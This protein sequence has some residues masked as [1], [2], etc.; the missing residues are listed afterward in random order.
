MRFDGGGRVDA[1][2]AHLHLDGL[3][4]VQTAFPTAR[5]ELV[6]DVD[7]PRRWSVTG[8]FAGGD[9]VVPVRDVD[10][11]PTAGREPIRRF[12]WKRAQQH[13]PGLEFLVSTG[14][15]HGYES[16]AEARLLLMLDFA[17]ELTD[18]LSQPLRLRFTTQDGLR[19]HIPD[20]F[21]ETR[22]GRW[23]IDV[24]PA[25]RVQPRDEVAFAATAEV[26]LLVG[27]GHL[28]VTGWRQFVTVTIDT[29]SA[30]R[31]PLTDQLGLVDD[32][33]GAVTAGPRTFG[34]L[35]EGTRAPAGFPV[36]SAVASPAG[37]GSGCPAE[38]SQPAHHSGR[39]ASAGDRVGPRGGCGGG[40]G[41]PGVDGGAGRTATGTRHPG[42]RR[43]RA[44]AGQH[45]VPDAPPGLPPE[46]GPVE[47]TVPRDREAS[48]E[49]TIVKK[50][51][52]RL[53][54]V[55]D[56]VISWSAKGLT[57]GEIAAH[58]AEIYGAEVSKQT[59]S[60]ITDRGMDGMGEWHN[61]P[62]DAVY[63]V[64][65]IDCV[66]VRIREGTVANRPI[67][68]ALA[69]TVEGTRDILGWW[70]GEH[71]DGEG[72]KYWLRV[73]SEIKNRGT[74]DVCI[75]VCDGLKGLPAA[76]GRVWPRTI[77]QTC[78]VHLL[79]NSFGYASRKDWGAIA[80]DLKPV[81]TA[82]GEQAALDRFAEFSEKWEAVTR[83]SCGCGPTRGR[84]LCRF[85]SSTP[86]SARSSARP[87]PSRASTRGSAGRSTPKT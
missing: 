29:Y 6:L 17:G 38:R 1:L 60:T 20:F 14:R 16:L 9:V 51:Q 63:P 76:V 35:A 42:E 15:H 26:A 40:V 68:V 34:E 81:Y 56:L 80:K 57:H 78:I 77:V 67:Y 31:R 39:Q 46:A 61:R 75:V 69:V 11:L 73:L 62:L 7:W 50:R 86:R 70:A 19:D 10:T 53:T 13:R 65:F 45:P 79:R 3:A 85:C 83:R 4:L 66:H 36:A 55:D 22:T 23:L 24:R 21:A 27:W 71:G 28:V 47:I 49:P 2:V 52:R 41:G 72:A 25:G 54:G 64:I 18:V 37:D 44:A 12:S 84:S 8:R 82:P 30:Q 43:R 33:L 87:M 32:L 59:I 48:V 5:Q 58:L 74:R